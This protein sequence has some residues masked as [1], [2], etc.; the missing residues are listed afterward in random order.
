MEKKWSEFKWFSVISAYF[1]VGAIL[2]CLGIW[3][4]GGFGSRAAWSSTNSNDNTDVGGSTGKPILLT[5]LTEKFNQ[6]GIRNFNEH[7]GYKVINEYPHGTKIYIPDLRFT[8]SEFKTH[9]ISVTAANGTSGTGTFTLV[10]NDESP[11]TEKE[12]LAAALHAT[13]KDSSY[14][15]NGIDYINA[16]RLIG[17]AEWNAS[18]C[19]FSPD[20]DTLSSD[21]GTWNTVV[22]ADTVRDTTSEELYEYYNLPKDTV[23]SLGYGTGWTGSI[24]FYRSDYNSVTVYTEGNLSTGATKTRAEMKMNGDR[25]MINGEWSVSGYAKQP[26]LNGAKYYDFNFRL[27]EEYKDYYVALIG[28]GVTELPSQNNFSPAY[29][30]VGEIWVMRGGTTAGMYVANAK[31]MAYGAYKTYDCGIN[32]LIGGEDLHTGWYLY[33]GKYYPGIHKNSPSGY[34]VNFVGYIW[35]GSNTVQNVTLVKNEENGVGGVVE[36]TAKKT[37]DTILTPPVVA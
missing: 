17:G 3:I 32:Q 28:A 2:F 14:T 23:E 16:V 36:V 20:E 29:G 21:G 6:F 30:F 12:Q 34:Q 13:G 10:T 7:N 9:T 33:N 4:S 19:M 22:F 31:V 8:T 1:C 24:E 27:G 18:H 11:Y 5:D 35:G 37:T 26:T 25:Y 15:N